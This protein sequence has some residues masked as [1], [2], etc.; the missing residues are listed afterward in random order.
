[1]KGVEFTLKLTDEESASIKE[2]LRV[3]QDSILRIR[4]NIKRSEAV[5][6]RVPVEWLESSDEFG[7]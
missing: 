2:L 7:L 5:T 4:E 6:G 3:L 1:M